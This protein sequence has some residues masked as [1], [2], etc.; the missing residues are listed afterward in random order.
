MKRCGRKRSWPKFK[1][2]SWCLP[3][4]TKGEKKAQVT[5]EYEAGV[6]TTRTRRLLERSNCRGC[7]PDTQYSKRQTLQHTEHWRSSFVHCTKSPVQCVPKG[8]FPGR[9]S[10][11][12][13]T[14]VSH[15]C[16]FPWIRLTETVFSRFL[17]Y[18][19]IFLPKYPQLHLLVRT[20]D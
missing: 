6:P 19:K 4:G 18:L 14:T 17:L 9:S 7:L 1:L 13:H 16:L 2:L 10:E 3:G 12:E 20:E 5:I 8:S 11:V 15:C